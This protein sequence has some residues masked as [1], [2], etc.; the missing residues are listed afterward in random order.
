M[1]SS[2]AL[3]FRFFLVILLFQVRC[4]ST[5]DEPQ[6]LIS[7]VR[8]KV[9]AASPVASPTEDFETTPIYINCG[10]ESFVAN[11]VKWSDDD[12][13]HSGGISSMT[14]VSVSRIDPELEL[15]Y[16]WERYD[17]STYSIPL[18][19]GDYLVRLHF[20]EIHHRVDEAGKRLFDVYLQDELVFDDLDIFSQV[21]IYAALVL[22]TNVTVMDNELKIE[23]RNGPVQSAK[24]NGVEIHSAEDGAPG[25]ISTP[26]AQRTEAT[27]V[28]TAQ[29]S[30][31]PISSA[32]QTS[33]PT[34]TPTH[35]LATTPIYINSGGGSF[36]ANDVTWSAD[37]FFSG[38][39]PSQKNVSIGGTEADMEPLY[40]SER[41]QDL[42]YSIPLEN[43]GYL[44][45]LHF[46]ET[47]HR[48]DEAGKRVFDVYVQDE[49]VFDDLDVFSQVGLYTALVLYTNV[50]V[51]DNELKIEIR[52]GP[53]QLAKISGLEVHASEK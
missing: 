25:S 32:P 39:R 14:N 11:N 37:E 53:V 35:A 45:R 17:S 43:G 31:T 28:P 4:G 10:G 2:I 3:M 12:F 34:T 27:S 49:L 47:F 50:T 46:A 26:T 19:N 30:E 7:G 13:H 36:V 23:F 38:G 51:V 8:N 52:N 29:A 18:E 20:A 48:I 24:I 15:L 22:D 9:F 44:V 16:Q 41:F 5:A 6:W 42:N 33:P 21:G 40:Q 1:S